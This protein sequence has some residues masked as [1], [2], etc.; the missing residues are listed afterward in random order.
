MKSRNGKEIELTADG[1]MVGTTFTYEDT[2]KRIPSPYPQNNESYRQYKQRVD[3]LVEEGFHL[4][5]LS[6]ANWQIYCIGGGQTGE[7]LDIDLP[8]G[9]I[10]P[11]RQ[12]RREAARLERERQ[13][14]K[15][16]QEQDEY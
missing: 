12:E 5:D 7:D 3:A 4:G 8:I 14:E 10:E 15:E 1:K 16:R 2:G 6:F 11:W 9:Y 13:E